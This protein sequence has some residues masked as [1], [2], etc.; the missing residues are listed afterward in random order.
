MNIALVYC[1]LNPSYENES[2]NAVS[3][4]SANAFGNP[5]YIEI[6]VVVVNICSNKRTDVFLLRDL[7]MLA[8]FLN[9]HM[10]NCT[11]N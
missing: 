3:Y 10:N 2:E 7:Q 1:S 11:L 5:S 9:D 4:S 8:I 6:Y